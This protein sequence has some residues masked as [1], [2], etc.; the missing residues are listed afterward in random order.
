MHKGAEQREAQ[1]LASQRDGGIIQAFSVR[2][3]L[4]RKA[5]IGAL[6]KMYW[7]AKEEIAHTTNFSSLMDLAI[8]L[9]S[10]Y[11]QEINL[12]GNAHYTS[13]QTVR[14]LLQTLSLVIEEE[15]LKDIQSSDFFALMTDKSTDIAV[16]KQL[17]LV[18]RC[19]TARGMKTAFLHIQDLCNGT[20][21]TIEAA[22]LQCLADNNL[23][24][25]RLGGF[26]S[27]GA[28]VMTGRGCGVATRLKNHSPRMVSV[29]C[30]NHRL[31]LA[32]VHASDGIPYLQCFKSILQMLFHFYQNSAVRMASLHSIQEVLNDPSIKCKQA[33]DVRW[34]SHDMAIKA[35]IHTLPSLL[36]SLDCKASENSEPTAHGLPNFMKSYKF[37]ACAYLLFDVLSHL[38]RLSC[39]F[40]KQDIDLCLV[41]N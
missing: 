20:A 16:L 34:L 10:D 5:L 9:S 18:A 24:I 41:Q 38:S 2:V 14:E 13:E 31:S 7:L 27:D 29:H 32:A 25:T 4:N 1:R 40:Q 6:K 19:M 11:L 23:G 36:V 22:I 35:V 21:E 28:S 17:V 3:S 30:V 12:G 33:K 39:I 26:G 8:Q 15:I 37:V